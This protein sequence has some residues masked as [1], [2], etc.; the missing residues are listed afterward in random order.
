MLQAE[1]SSHFYYSVGFSRPSTKIDTKSIICKFSLSVHPLINVFLKESITHDL[2]YLNFVSKI[3]DFLKRKLKFLISRYSRSSKQNRN[4]SNL[5]LNVFVKIVDF[6][7]GCGFNIM[8]F[9]KESI[10]D[11]FKYLWD[12][13]LECFQISRTC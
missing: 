9:L 4:V 11:K 6:T 1:F 10:T 13:F 12:S 8:G 7:Q 3:L 2:A 5:F